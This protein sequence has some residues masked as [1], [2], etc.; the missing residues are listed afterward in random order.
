MWYRSKA[1][2]RD[3]QNLT[4]HG[5]PRIYRKRIRKGH[6]KV[7]DLVDEVASVLDTVYQYLPTGYRY[8]VTTL[9]SKLAAVKKHNPGK[10]VRII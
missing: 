1:K 2:E 8:K 5:T 6:Q 9:A 4:A 3:A 7:V 10:Q